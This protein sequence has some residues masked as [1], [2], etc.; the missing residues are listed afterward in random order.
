MTKKQI[1]NF[2]VCFWKDIRFAITEQ[3]K[4]L[5]HFFSVIFVGINNLSFGRYFWQASKEIGTY[6]K[7]WGNIVL[8]IRSSQEQWLLV[9]ICGFV[10][11]RCYSPIILPQRA[12]LALACI[13][14]DIHLEYLWCICCFCSHNFIFGVISC[15]LTTS[16]YLEKD[17]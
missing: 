13:V 14:P 9:K 8:V 2:F 16:I 15:Q 12:F 10:W 7:K 5:A 1:F 3:S 4:S 17:L 11:Q 6:W